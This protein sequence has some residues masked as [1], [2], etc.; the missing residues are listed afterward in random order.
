MPGI[1]SYH[2]R[3]VALVLSDGHVL[4][5][6]AG[7]RRA[8]ARRLQPVNVRSTRRCAHAGQA[9]ARGASACR[10]APSRPACCSCTGRR[11][12][13]GS[14]GQGG[15]IGAPQKGD[16]LY[17]GS[18]HRVQNVGQHMHRPARVV[19]A[20]PATDDVRLLTAG[21]AAGG[22]CVV[23]GCARARACAWPCSR[24]VRGQAA[25]HSAAQAAWPAWR[26]RGGAA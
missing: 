10:A 13:P 9:Q 14:V 7:Q 11:H 26:S 12:P 16:Q 15:I 1:S 6:P 5:G 19:A 2:G 20:V 18:S 24:G 17:V 4:L 8:P 22:G 3:Q 21:G 25:R 23:G